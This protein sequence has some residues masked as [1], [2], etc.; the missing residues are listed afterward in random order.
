MFDS[1][2][3]EDILYTNLKK[4]KSILYFTYTGNLV[5]EYMF[6]IRQKLHK[7]ISIFM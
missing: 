2:F 4:N 5:E 3:S 7:D 1:F 6:I